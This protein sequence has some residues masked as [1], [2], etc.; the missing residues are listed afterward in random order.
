MLPGRE[1]A[2]S[3][4]ASF[5]ER[6]LGRTLLRRV[7][8]VRHVALKAS[9]GL[10]DGVQAARASHG[11]RPTWNGFDAWIRPFMQP[12]HFKGYR[13]H[14][15]YFSTLPVRN[16]L[17]CAR[18]SNIN[19]K[20]CGVSGACAFMVINKKYS[21][22]ISLFGFGGSEINKKYISLAKILKCGFFLPD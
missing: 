8:R 18:F 17:Y 13:L 7:V 9:F 15:Q 3:V 11:S 14:F 10:G 22:R 1:Q 21:T 19:L 2:R 20:N 12:P 6:N 5:W 16:F 4:V